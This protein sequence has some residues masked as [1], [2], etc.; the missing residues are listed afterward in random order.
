MYTEYEYE[1]NIYSEETRDDMID[2][3]ALSPMEAAFM[4]GYDAAV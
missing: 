4:D 2:S 3:D 1:E